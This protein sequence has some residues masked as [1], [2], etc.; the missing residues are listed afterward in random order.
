MDNS[1]IAAV[2]T[3][4][5]LWNPANELH[6]NSNML[7]KLWQEIAE[8]LQ[9]DVK[10]LKTRWKNLR[11]Y[12]IKECQKL[13]KSKNKHGGGIRTWQY[14]DQLQFLR[15]STSVLNKIAEDEDDDD[16]YNER[17]LPPAPPANHSANRANV[18]TEGRLTAAGRPLAG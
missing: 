8:E 7:R 16:Y 14:F 3:R 17:G 12:F 5:A 15:N 13:E 1:L 9:K 6:K 2:Y 11:T 4:E 18:P 10:S